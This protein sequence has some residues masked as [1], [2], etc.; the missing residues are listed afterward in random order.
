MQRDSTIRFARKRCQAKSLLSFGTGG[1]NEC[2]AT[3]TD[4]ATLASSRSFN[5]ASTIGSM[6]TEQSLLVFVSVKLV[7]LCTKSTLHQAS[8][9]HL[10]L[11]PHP[12]KVQVHFDGS[13]WSHIDYLILIHDVEKFTGQFLI[14]SPEHPLL[15]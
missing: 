4:L 9:A 12:L 15:L 14:Q 13:F 8:L 11:A 5:S 6:D 3:F 10:L 2:Q 1:E 7:V